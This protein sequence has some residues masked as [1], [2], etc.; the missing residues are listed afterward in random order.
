MQD[1]YD[2][3]KAENAEIFAISI[4]NEPTIKRTVQRENLEFLVL[5]DTDL[6]AVKPFNVEVPVNTGAVQP[7]SFLIESDGTIV[8]KSVDTV[9]NRVPTQRIMD[10]LSKLW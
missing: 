10:A 1:N 7:S 3:I 4:E 2:R 6:E 5:S 8:W 9:D